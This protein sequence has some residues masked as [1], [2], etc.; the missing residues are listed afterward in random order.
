MRVGWSDLGS[1][2]S[3]WKE[4]KKDE[5]GNSIYGNVILDKSE[6]CFLMSNNRLLVALGIKDLIVVE[7][8]DALLV[9]NKEKDQDVKK[10]VSILNKKTCQ[11]LIFT[12]KDLDHGETINQLKREK[13]AS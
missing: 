1:W 4:S 7:T 8:H 6:N 11:K 2:N 10:I 3:L 13:L 9:V 5:N 12:I